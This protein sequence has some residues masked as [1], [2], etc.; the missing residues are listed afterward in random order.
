MSED[1]YTTNLA[2]YDKLVDTYPDIKRKGKANPYTSLNGHMFSFLMKEGHLALRMSKTDKA[3]FEEKYQ[4]GPCISYN[5]VM[6]EYVVVPDEILHSLDK[7]QT[8]F[9]MS[10]AYVSSLK[11]KPTTKRKK[12]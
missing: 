7:V 2:Q 11:P 1:H 3:A 10:F 6:K 9:D 8:Y 12:K 4:T 5:T